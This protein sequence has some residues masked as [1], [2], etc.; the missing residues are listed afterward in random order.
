MRNAF[1]AASRP[2]KSMGMRMMSTTPLKGTVSQVIGAVVV[3]LG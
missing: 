3:R 2:G 1:R